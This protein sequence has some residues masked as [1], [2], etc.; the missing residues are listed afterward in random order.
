MTTDPNSNTVR[1]SQDIDDAIDKVA[2][3]LAMADIMSFDDARV[4][5]RDFCGRAVTT[6]TAPAVS[7]A[8]ADAVNDN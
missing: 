5:L 6:A 1:P 7:Q 2:Q 4:R 3:S 8:L